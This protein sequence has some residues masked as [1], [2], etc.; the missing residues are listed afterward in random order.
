MIPIDVLQSV[1]LIQ[2]S[3]NTASS[4]TYECDQKVFLV[5]A[6]HLFYSNEVLKSSFGR[7]IYDIPDGHFQI[8]QNNNWEILNG[9]VYFHENINVDIAI[10]ELINNVLPFAS[11]T[12]DSQSLS[13]G[14]DVYFLGYPLTLKSWLLYSTSPYPLPLVKKAIIAG[15]NIH[16][17]GDSV[18]YLDTQANPGFSGGPVIF[19]QHENDKYS[20]CGIITAGFASQVFGKS[21]T[22]SISYEEDS[23][24]TIVTHISHLEEIICRLKS[25][26]K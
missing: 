9:N 15:I 11:L 17:N 22:I 14:Q 25:K 8:F 18:L 20:I 23:G 13:I 21:H 3:N 6:R 2:Y 24:I 5:T 12:I 19:K 26:N 10:I 7:K 4:F 1:Y 16:E